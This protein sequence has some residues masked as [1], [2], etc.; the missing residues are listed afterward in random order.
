MMAENW[1]NRQCALIG[2]DA[3]EKLKNASVMIF[4]IGG[5]G[6]FASEAIVRAGVGRVIFVDGDT[7]SVTNINRQLIADTTTV[8]QDKAEIMANR[9]L[10]INPECQVFFERVFVDKTNCDELLDKY[11]PDFIIDCIDTV[12][13]KLLIIRWATENSVKIISSMGTGNKLDPSKFQITDIKNTSVCPLA[14]VMRRELKNMGI[15]ALPVLFSTEEP[16]RTGE[17]VPASISFVPSSAG[18]MMAGYV[19]RELIK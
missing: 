1:L 15:T 4:G 6:S 11:C 18:L 14:R 13:S 12:S 7:V 3:T 5:V 17:R 9:A 8:G 16:V 10:V 2:K 19:V